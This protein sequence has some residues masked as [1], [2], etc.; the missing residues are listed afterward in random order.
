MNYEFLLVLA[1]EQG[2]EAN[3]SPA[4]LCL[5]GTQETKELQSGWVQS[6]EGMKSGEQD[7]WAQV[8]LQWTGDLNTSTPLAPAYKHLSNARP[9][10]Q[11]IDSEK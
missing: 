1:A 9:E 2:E 10:F 6:G 8:P 11:Q 4:Y 5:V 3:I 7:L